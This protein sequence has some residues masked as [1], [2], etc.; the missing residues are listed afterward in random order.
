MH[1][2][3]ININSFYYTSCTH[4]SLEECWQLIHSKENIETPGLM[5]L[6]YALSFYIHHHFRVQYSCKI[7]GLISK[8]LSKLD[9]CMA[10]WGKPNEPSLQH[11]VY[12]FM[13]YVDS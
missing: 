1:L 9:E 2:P 7:L 3:P 8:I 12:I 11:H 6:N 13:Q 5:S 4:L 10:L